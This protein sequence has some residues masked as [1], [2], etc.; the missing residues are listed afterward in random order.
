MK[1][2][3]RI[4]PSPSDSAG[5][6]SEPIWQTCAPKPL[7]NWNALWSN[8]RMEPSL[9]LPFPVCQSCWTGDSG[10]M[11]PYANHKV[12]WLQGWGHSTSQRSCGRRSGHLQTSGTIWDTW[13]FT[14]LPLK[15]LRNLYTCTMDSILC[16]SI[17]KVLKHHPANSVSCSHQ[18]AAG[19]QRPKGWRTVFYPQVI[20]PLNLEP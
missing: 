1:L 2:W 20:C 6:R 15:V 12:T 19:G 18:A 4:P 13:T 17:I 14:Q 5:R 8:L 16:G 7:F 10:W 3:Q 11:S 9:L